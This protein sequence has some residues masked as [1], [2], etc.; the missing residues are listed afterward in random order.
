[1]D[2][3]ADLQNL[4]LLSLVS[5]ITTE[6]SNHLG[7]TDK[8]LSEFVIDIHGQ[9]ASLDEF[10]AKLAGH[11]VE[12]PNSLAETID[13]LILTM[14]PKHRN[15]KPAKQN[16]HDHS[17][18]DL[19]KKARVFRGLAMPDRDP[20]SS[21]GY[22]NSPK[23]S[24]KDAI[25]DTLAAFEK[26]EPKGKAAGK[27]REEPVDDTLALLES[28][29]PG[30]R[31]AP[32]ARNDKPLRKRSLSP[33]ESGRSKR[34]NLRRSRSLSR[35][36]SPS[37]DRRRGRRSGRDRG[38]GMDEFGRSGRVDRNGP[39]KGYGAGRRGDDGFRRP[40]TP[41]VDDAPTLFK[42]YDGRI[43]GLQ[44]FGAFVSLNGVKGQ[45]GKRHAVGLVHVSAIREGQ[46]VN[47]PSD[48]LSVDQ[49]VKVKV[50]S[51]QGD[52]IGLSMKDVDQKTGLDL[53]P[54]KRI[55]SG[56]NSEGLHGSS[57]SSRY[58][59]LDS[60]VPVLEGEIDPKAMRTKKRLTSPE[61]WEIKQLISSGALSARDYPEIDEEYHATL[62]GE[63]EFEEEED[64]D[65]EVKG[66]EPPFLAGQTKQ[67][68]ELSPIRVV[69]A[70]DGSLNRAAMAGTTLAKE[71]RELRQQQASDAAAEEAQKVDLSAQWQDPMVAVG[72]HQFASDLKNAN[73]NPPQDLPEWKRVTMSK[74]TSFGRI[75][76]LSIREQR[77]SLPVYKLRSSLSRLS[78]KTS[79]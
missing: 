32:P 5:K 36:R 68:L 17:I 8:T 59:N 31:A 27:R 22:L 10:K 21:T 42:V 72:Q 49:V 51:V 1:M 39:G 70:P 4:E 30:S 38:D 23:D 3:L 2:A 45:N 35:S 69:K 14:H 73:A 75:T 79:C 52:R 26:L 15:K 46:R 76:T 71:R 34:R 11:G 33:Y 16:G 63:G 44:N 20:W 54:A 61:R 64:I 43:S 67:S 65:I 53:D 29:A 28:M 41:E 57:K 50:I 13:R 77:Q 24:G 62:N 56:A 78:T 12:F 6:L 19:D 58:G 40:P 55:A 18:G 66:E 48:L 25:D 47:H 7:V 37:P 74:N 9:C 60:A